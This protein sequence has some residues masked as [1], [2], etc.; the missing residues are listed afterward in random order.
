MTLTSA[1]SWNRV[2]CLTQ[3]ASERTASGS[4]GFSSAGSSSGVLERGH[5]HGFEVGGGRGFG[6][7]AASATA[8]SALGREL[9]LGRVLG[10]RL[11]AVPAA[12]Q[13]G[14]AYTQ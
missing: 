3:Q 1:S 10:G 12:G 8:A 5:V 6:R 2:S 11:G 9:G 7:L 4:F 13:E 14:I